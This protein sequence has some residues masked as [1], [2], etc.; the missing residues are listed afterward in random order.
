MRARVLLARER[1]DENTLVC[2]RSRWRVSSGRRFQTTSL[3]CREE[4]SVKRFS[5]LNFR[6]WRYFRVHGLYFRTD[7]LSICRNLSMSYWNL[8]YLWISLLFF[9]F[10]FFLFFERPAYIFVI[11]RTCETVVI[12]VQNLV[13]IMLSLRHQGY[14]IQ[15]SMNYSRGVSVNVK[16]IFGATQGD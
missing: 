11:K 9:S 12:F 10:F 7:R 8:W 6:F 14:G 15:I 3:A 16:T 1:L 4:M 2:P 13:S 5:F